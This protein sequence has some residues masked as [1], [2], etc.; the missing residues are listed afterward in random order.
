MK[1]LLNES[2]LDFSLANFSIWTYVPVLLLALF[3]SSPAGNETRG[4][5]VSLL[6]FS[7]LVNYFSGNYAIL[8]E[9]C[10]G[11]N[12]PIYHFATPVY[13]FLL[14]Q[15]YRPY[16]KRL[17]AAPLQWILLLVAVVIGLGDIVFGVGLYQFPT[18]GITFYSLA[19]IMLPVGY[20][21]Y[22]LQS[23]AVN[24]LEKDPLFVVSAGFLINFSGNFLLWVFLNYITGDY[25]IFHSVY[26]VNSVLAILLNFFL[27]TAILICPTP[28]YLNSPSITT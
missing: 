9:F 22:L 4:P 20:F 11:T 28:K 14:L 3:T 18:L 1:Y 8:V 23:L 13:V 15:I 25:E 17:S 19:G 21:Y 2:F 12:A 6:I 27:A 16:L 26:R 5:V 24:R 7:V 10:R